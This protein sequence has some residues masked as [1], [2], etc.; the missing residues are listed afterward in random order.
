ME[1]HK[2][3]YYAVNGIT[4]FRVI[5][6][7]FLLVLLLT[8]NY[9]CFKWLLGINFFTDLIDGYLAR[10][11]KVT[12]IAGAKLDSIGDDLTIV[13]AIVGLFV[14]KPAFIKQHLT[15]IVIAFSLFLIQTG[16]ALIR[17]GKITSFHT[18]LAKTAAILQGVFFL[19]FFFIDSSITILF[20]AA[21][22][23]TMLE[24]VEEIIL[25]SILPKWEANIKGLPWVIKNKKKKGTG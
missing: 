8:D 18:Y 22:S 5:A 12:S 6:A 25:V 3:A 9:N 16:Y 1:K 4:L 17:Y 24:L 23:V 14:T 10:R 19:V 15:L 7:P 13:A 11:Y 21:V 20:Y 2:P